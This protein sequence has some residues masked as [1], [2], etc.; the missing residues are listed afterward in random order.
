MAKNARLQSGW[1]N[2]NI[3]PG[4]K[5]TK[6]EFDAVAD[7]MRLVTI[8]T[9][10]YTPKAIGQALKKLGIRD[11]VWVIGPAGKELWKLDGQLAKQL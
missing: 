4:C 1:D 11:S 7:K 9:C 10:L 3:V 5:I 6:M 2:L 8:A